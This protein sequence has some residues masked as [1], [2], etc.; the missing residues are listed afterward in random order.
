MF[1][2]IVSRPVQTAFVAFEIEVSWALSVRIDL[3]LFADGGQRRRDRRGIHLDLALDE[4]GER[5]QAGKPDR[6]LERG[7]LGIVR[8][9]DAVDVVT[10]QVER[11]DPRRR[12]GLAEDDD[13][14]GRSPVLLR[15]SRSSSRI[16]RI[17]IGRSLASMTTLTS[18]PR[19][20]RASRVRTKS[21]FFD[22][23]TE[24]VSVPVRSSRSPAPR[25]RSASIA[26]RRS[27]KSPPLAVERARSAP[28]AAAAA[29]IATSRSS[30]DLKP[31]VISWR[32]W[33]IGEW[34]RVGSSRIGELG[35]VAVEVALEHRADPADRAVALRLVE[36]LVDHRAQ[37]AAV[38]EELLE[39]A[40]QAAVAVGEVG[41]QR[42]L[43]RLGGLLVD[44]SRPGA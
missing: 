43:E 12:V 36:Q 19:A 8:V 38:A 44:R 14:D 1:E 29:S 41:A 10:D 18:Q 33:C 28:R 9:D 20:T 32:N 4:R 40:R 3:D 31:S 13:R 42:L 25:A 37:R 35:R 17:D 6:R 21:P 2:R 11:G 27:S 24:P 15:A 39:R 7:R 22:L 30:S 26:S 34:S 23:M 16:A 5:E